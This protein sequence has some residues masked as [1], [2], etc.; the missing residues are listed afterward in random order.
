MRSGLLHA[1]GSLSGLAQIPKEDIQALEQL[2]KAFTTS[3][4]HL[5]CAKNTRLGPDFGKNG[6]VPGG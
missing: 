6:C 2:Y 5:W 1:A 3:Q 4:Q